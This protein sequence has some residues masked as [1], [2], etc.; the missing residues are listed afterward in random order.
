M[1]ELTIQVEAIYD[2][3]SLELIPP[4]PT[5]AT[6]DLHRCAICHALAPE[7]TAYH[8]KCRLADTLEVAEQA[9]ARIISLTHVSRKNSNDAAAYYR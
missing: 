1:W 5:S 8:A 4:L 6:L 9:A 7:G 3:G 2:H